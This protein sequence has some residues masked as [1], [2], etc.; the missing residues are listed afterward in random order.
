VVERLDLDQTAP[1]GESLD[2][3]HGGAERMK[4]VA[5]CPGG[6]GTRRSGKPRTGAV[7]WPSVAI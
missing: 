5:D 4:E 2:L 3:D 7:G 6:T 1:V